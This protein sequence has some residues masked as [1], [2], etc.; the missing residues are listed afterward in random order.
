MLK[1]FRESTVVI[2]SGMFLFA[3]TITACNSQES[4]K[5]E[6][7]TTIKPADT[8]PAIDTAHMDSAT[9]RPV[10]GGN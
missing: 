2:L 1:N 4:E 5:A 6:E 8:A 9:T 3:V 7:P 10:K